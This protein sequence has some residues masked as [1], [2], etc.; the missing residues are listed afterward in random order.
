M[1][2][3]DALMHGGDYADSLRDYY[4]RYPQ[5]GYGGR[6]RDWAQS[7]LRAPYG[8]YGNGAAM[9]VS[10]VAWFYTSLPEVLA[11][12]ERSAAVTHDHPEGLRGA[13]TVAGAIFMAKSGCSKRQIHAWVSHDNGYNLE[14]SCDAIRPT[15]TFDVSC[16]GTVPPAMTAFL[17][18]TSFE[19]SVRL[20]VSLGGDS[21]TLTCITASVSEAFYDGVPADIATRALAFLDPQ[22]R[23]TLQRFFTRTG[24]PLPPA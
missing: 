3:A 10:P 16:Q 6:F 19:E 17:E 18:S 7:G 14:Q 9:R 20:A 23:E 24:R 13:R 15:Y 8:S 1:A 12:A 5:A 11:A 4:H 21:D 2:L 22:L